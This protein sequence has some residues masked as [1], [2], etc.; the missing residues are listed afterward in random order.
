M[1]KVMAFITVQNTYDSHGNFLLSQK[2]KSPITIFSINFAYILY[3]F[4]VI[5]GGYKFKQGGYVPYFPSDQ[6]IKKLM[7]LTDPEDISNILKT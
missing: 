5:K 2:T 3:F 1:I 6:E 7:L 4:S